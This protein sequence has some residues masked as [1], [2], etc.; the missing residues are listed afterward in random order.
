VAYFSKAMNPAE[1]N[2]VIHDKELL[3][4]VASLMYF[5]HYL[6]GAK[7]TTDIWT[8]HSNLKYFMTKQK[9]TRR[10][11]RWALTLSRF[12]F[13][14]THHPGTHNKSDALSRRPD[15]REGVEHDNEERVLLDPKSFAI[16]A[17]RPG[18]VVTA[19]DPNLRKRLKETQEHDPE[20]SQ[21][22]ATILRNG[23]RSITKGLEDWNLEEG[24]ILFRGKIYVPKSQELRRD[25]VKMHHDSIAT[26]HPGRW[27]TYEL[28]TQNYWWPGISTFVKDYV[29]GCATCQTTKKLPK[30]IV[31]LKPNPV[32]TDVWQ[33][34]T[35]DF[36][37]DLP[38]S[39]GFDSLLVTVDRFSK[40]TIIAP[41]NK[42]ITADETAQLYLDQV[43]RRTGLPL[44]IISD[45]GPQ[46]ASKVI[47]EVWKKLN[48]KSALSTA[49]HPQT[50]GET[51]RVN[52]ELE[53]YLRIFCNYQQ[54]NW[55]DLIPFMEFA[56]N[57]RPHSAM[58][59]S[60]FEVWYGFTPTFIPP[61]QVG[62]N[63][64]TVES[65]LKTLDQ[66]RTEVAASLR[67][68]AEIMKRS[69]PDGPEFQFKENDLV[70]L[71]GTN[72]QTTH[73]KAKLA[74]KRHGPF[75]VLAAYPVNCY[76]E[77]P[78]TWKIHPVF[79]NSLLKLYKETPAHGPNFTR[80]PPEVINDEPDHYEV[81]QIL[82]SK[83]TRNGRGVAYLVSW[84]GYSDSENTWEPAR[85][86]KN[87]QALVDE[88]HK[89]NPKKPNPAKLVIKLLTEQ[90]QLKEGILSRTV[91]LTKTSSRTSQVPRVVETRRLTINPR[92][93]TQWQQRNTLNTSRKTE[94]QQRQTMWEYLTS[95]LPIPA[96]KW[97]E[98]PLSSSLRLG[99][100]R[101]RNSGPMSA[102]IR[103]LTAAQSARLRP[104]VDGHT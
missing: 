91:T 85:N 76:L 100:P 3:A 35:M 16:R 2:Y 87:S 6:E 63:N 92:A 69:R 43:W 60:P 25:I 58:G 75:K 37:V 80:P 64:P 82:D 56:H 19:G 98:T 81:E 90:Q 96:K 26:G 22:L 33:E 86:L 48:V 13:R 84:A 47:Q 52:Q 1:R 94:T 67:N 78:R 38:K 34:I 39:N 88:F 10:Q 59:K 61:L 27:K 24:L 49:Y 21:A 15:H 103:K 54:D 101:L 83:F 102:E 89:H 23:P 12:D 74:P 14:I 36:I 11:A 44:R 29:E 104:L 72:I 45:R 31:P 9:L 62:S 46:F 68:A 28:V 66:L 40:A 18:A 73:P 17:T 42:T 20:V 97:L 30:T 53:Q 57:A 70:W 95:P 79:H 7:N 32:P 55:A 51:E 50:D 99:A 41:C 4:I 5:R 71:E 65:R 77:L 8:D 93:A